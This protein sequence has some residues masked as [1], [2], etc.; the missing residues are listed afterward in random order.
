MGR[1]Q[2]NSSVKP[3]VDRARPRPC[4]RKGCER[5][6]RPVRW[7]QRYCGDPSCHR[8]ARR[9]H[10]VKRQRAYRLSPENRKR[11]ADAERGRRARAKE[12]REKLPPAVGPSAEPVEAT[13][14][15]RA[16]SRG[17]IIPLNFCDRPGCYE[18]LPAD[19]RAPARYCGGDCRQALRRARD[20]E[21]K[22]LVRQ[23]Y[24]VMT[25][26]RQRRS[27][28]SSNA[29]RTERVV[30]PIPNRSTDTAPPSLGNRVGDYG[31][32]HA[33][34]LSSSPSDVSPAASTNEDGHTKTHS[35]CRSRPPPA[36]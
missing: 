25:P 5:T 15:G 22:C 9:W 13:T 16:W 21:R 7:N 3:T 28:W 35:R 23:R 27:A 14:Q 36:S 20:R 18:P 8:E 31:K 6:F 34:G 19:S 24:R 10:A 29:L 32:G 33:L 17:R 11:H 26:V 1:S 12:N 30:D 2:N 4:L